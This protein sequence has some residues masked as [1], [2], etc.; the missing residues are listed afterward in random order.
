MVRGCP[1]LTHQVAPLSLHLPRQGCGVAFF[2]QQRAQY[3]YTLFFAFQAVFPRRLVAAVNLF[4]AAFFRNPKNTGQLW[5]AMDNLSRL[6]RLRFKKSGQRKPN[7]YAM[8]RLSR[9][10]PTI[11]NMNQMENSISGWRNLPATGLLARRF[12]GY[13]DNPPIAASSCAARPSAPC[14]CMPAR[15]DRAQHGQAGAR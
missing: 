1:V 8:S 14:G 10:V 3:L 2:I 9:L 15:S 11:F 12:L 6:S 7:R 4:R 5:T 13:P